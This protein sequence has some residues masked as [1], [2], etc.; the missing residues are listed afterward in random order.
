M[1]SL[2]H[3]LF[4]IALCNICLYYTFSNNTLTYIKIREGFITEGIDTGVFWPGANHLRSMGTYHNL[5]QAE[6]NAFGKCAQLN[7]D[8]NYGKQSIAI[9]AR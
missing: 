5:F 3:N 1:I 7:R 9:F 8:S 6:V 2:V 4:F